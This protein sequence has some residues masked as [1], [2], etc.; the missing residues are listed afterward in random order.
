MA[1]GEPVT[2]FVPCG[3]VD[4]ADLTRGER[5]VEGGIVRRAQHPAAIHRVTTRRD[6]RH[7]GAWITATG[8]FVMVDDGDVDPRL[9]RRRRLG[10]EMLIR[11]TW[12][13]RVRGYQQHHRPM[14][15]DRRTRI[16]RFA[17]P[18]TSRADE[19]KRSRR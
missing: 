18:A 17:V 12:P 5:R 8:Q 15:V 4:Q 10:R 2:V 9:A 3:I 6:T 16:H 11:T 13:Q 14:V 19:M 7:R 1:A